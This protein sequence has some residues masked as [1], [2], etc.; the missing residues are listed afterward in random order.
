MNSPDREFFKQVQDEINYRRQLAREDSNRLRNRIWEDIGALQQMMQSIFMSFW[1][2]SRNNEDRLWKLLER[3]ARQDPESFL[4]IVENFLLTSSDLA[5]DVA[6]IL[7]NP[8]FLGD[9]YDFRMRVDKMTDGILAQGCHNQ[10]DIMPD[11][12]TGVR[13][14]DNSQVIGV[15]GRDFTGTVQANID[16]LPDAPQGSKTDIKDLL[17]QLEREVQEKFASDKEKQQ[18]ALKKLNDLA[19]AAQEPQIEENKEKAHDAID[20]LRNI[21]TGLGGASALFN[22]IDKIRPFFGL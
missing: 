20:I 16:R 6:R 1:G 11:D 8:S 5:P 13:V 7:R 3:R 4:K 12:H 18:R 2:G 14:G 22:I 9:Q 19:V 21:A 15:A 17:R 10:G